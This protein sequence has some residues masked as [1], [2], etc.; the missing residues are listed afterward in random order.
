MS[1][2]SVKEDII[3]KFKKNDIYDYYEKM[4][5]D[6][7]DFEYSRR[8][9]DVPTAF[10]DTYKYEVEYSIGEFN[11]KYGHFNCDGIMLVPYFEA[12][13]QTII[14]G[15]ELNLQVLEKFKQ[16]YPLEDDDSYYYFF[17]ILNVFTLGSCYGIVDGEVDI[18]DLDDLIDLESENSESD[19]ES[20]DV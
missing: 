16:K 8:H 9:F 7:D 20:D 4:L 14:R 13:G 18:V 3:D 12:D 2:D 10:G 1:F 6:V 19:S 17:N 5:E 11:F 15:L